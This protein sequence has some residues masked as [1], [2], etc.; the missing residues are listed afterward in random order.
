MQE[1]FRGIEV[2]QASIK[3]LQ[4]RGVKKAQAESNYRIALGKYLLEQ[5]EK[6]V[7]VTIIK[8]L[9]R[10]DRTVARLRLERDIADVIYDSCQQSIY[11]TKI[12]L[13]I[14]SDQIKREGDRYADAR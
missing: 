12:E 11:A 14:L 2:L 9:A 4:A 10:G 7:P 13:N 1:L 3:E 6:G 8:D 5:R